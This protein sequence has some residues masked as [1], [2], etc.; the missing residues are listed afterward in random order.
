M[1]GI[2]C[3]IVEFVFV[4][5]TWQHSGL[6]FHTLLDLQTV[7]FILR[8]CARFYALVFSSW[9]W[10]YCRKLCPVVSTATFD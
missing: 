5:C 8:Y 10:C 7:T 9:N 4:S 6:H 3:D 1:C 2:C